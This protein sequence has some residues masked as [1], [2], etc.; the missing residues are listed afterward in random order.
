[1]DVDLKQEPNALR[2]RHSGGG[3]TQ[4]SPIAEQ[5]ENDGELYA[6]KAADSANEGS[7]ASAEN[8]GM[9]NPVSSASSDAPANQVRNDDQVCKQEEDDDVI[10]DD[11]M[12][13][14]G[15]S[16]TQEMTPA[17]R[18]AARRKMKRFRYGNWSCLK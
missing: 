11:D 3:H 17:E 7:V 9:S 1:M 6:R 10:D 4:P 18:T 13:G 12:D 14:D 5:V 8:Q 15:E 16:G 2:Q